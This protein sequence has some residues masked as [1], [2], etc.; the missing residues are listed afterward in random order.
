MASRWSLFIDESGGFSPGETSLV[1]GV[2]VAREAASLDG[3]LREALADVWG[4]A[5][6]P[7]HATDL[8]R[9]VSR[10]LYAE[11]APRRAG[12]RMEPGR[13]WSAMRGPV[14]ALAAALEGSAFAGR[15]AAIRGGAF[16]TWADMV[17]AERVVRTHAAYPALRKV[18]EDQDLAMRGL[19]GRVVSRLGAGSVSIVGALADG[20]PPGP[21]PARAAVREDAYVRA[22]TA[23]V[24]RV[25]RLGDGAEIDLRVLTRGVEVGGLGTIPMQGHFLRP[26][27]EE[28][29]RRAGA[30][31]RFVTTAAA[32]RYG[33]DADQGRPFHPMLAVADWVANRL[34]HVADERPRSYDAL[35]ERL[36]AGGVV[37]AAELLTR[38]PILAPQV[39]ALPTIGAAGPPEAAVRAAFRG[40]RPELGGPGPKWAWAQAAAWVDAAGRWA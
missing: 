35:V 2:L 3:T 37:P 12:A 23:V 27:A 1:A 26:L 30:R 21:P 33:D 34:R 5:P 32:L 24:E 38:A 31:P 20:E 36:V 14:R 10:V 13:F 9:P 4:P 40:T 8:R 16:P 22:L 11:W 25:A 17:E 6:F 29:A 28:A 39:G 7:P 18:A 19:L 15:L